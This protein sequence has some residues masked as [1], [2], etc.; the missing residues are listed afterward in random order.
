[1]YSYGY[2]LSFA[3][4]LDKKRMV[5]SA[6]WKKGIPSPYQAIIKV[7]KVYTPIDSAW[8]NANAQIKPSLFSIRK[9][10]QTN[11]MRKWKGGEKLE[12]YHLLL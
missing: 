4:I 11:N 12:W 6:D 10:K 3:M 7:Y 2:G 5:E 8:C 9:N 1:M